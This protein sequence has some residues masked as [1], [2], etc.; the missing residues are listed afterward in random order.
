MSSLKWMDELFTFY[1]SLPTF[2]KVEK[3][4]MEEYQSLFKGKGRRK[5][6]GGGKKTFLQKLS[7]MLVD[8]CMPKIIQT[9]IGLHA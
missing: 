7:T 3:A 4:L 6:R 9:V 5:R 1:F 8:N 2:L